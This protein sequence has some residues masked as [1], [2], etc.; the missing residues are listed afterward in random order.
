MTCF[1]GE[2]EVEILRFFEGLPIL[3]V[4][5]ST[6]R[7]VL[8][9]DGPEAEDISWTA[10]AV[11]ENLRLVTGSDLTSSSISKSPCFRFTLCTYGFRFCLSLLPTGR[12][13]ALFGVTCL[14]PSTGEAWVV[15]DVSAV[16]SDFF[17]CG[18]SF[19]QEDSVLSV[20]LSFSPVLRPL[21]GR[22]GEFLVVLEVGDLSF[23]TGFLVLGECSGF[24]T[25]WSHFSLSDMVAVPEIPLSE[26]FNASFRGL[27]GQFSTLL[28][29][30]SFVVSVALPP[31]VAGLL[32]EPV[33][34]GFT[35][36]T[37][38]F[39]LDE[40]VLSFCTGIK[41]FPWIRYIFPVVVFATITCWLLCEEVPLAMMVA[42]MGV[43]W[44]WVV[45]VVAV[46][47]C[48]VWIP[49]VL[50]STTWPPSLSDSSWVF[51]SDGVFSCCRSS[52]SEERRSS[53]L[54]EGIAGRSFFL[55]TLASWVPSESDFSVAPL[56]SSPMA[57]GSSTVL[58]TLGF[59]VIP[60]SLLSASFTS[61]PS[62]DSL[63]GVSLLAVLLKLSSLSTHT[64]RASS[65][66][67]PVLSV[68]HALEAPS[69]VLTFPVP[70]SFF[71]LVFPFSLHR[72]SNFP[73]L[74]LVLSAS[75]PVDRVLS[76]VLLLSS[77]APLK[78]PILESV[79]EATDS[80]SLSV[81]V[82]C[83]SLFDFSLQSTI[84]PSEGSFPP[85]HVSSLSSLLNFEF[86]S[87]VPTLPSSLTG[88]SAQLSAS[89]GLVALSSTPS[90]S[91]P[92]FSIDC[93]ATEVVSTAVAFSGFTSSPSHWFPT[94]LLILHED[95]STL[96][97]DKLSKLPS[98]WPS[99]CL[100]TDL[101]SLDS[102]TLISLDFASVFSHPF[103]PIV[104][105][106]SFLCPSEHKGSSFI[107]E[108]E[109]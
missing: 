109:T 49:R 65:T 69:I 32:P 33:V 93:G 106:V 94:S 61:S 2:L 17:E 102:L 99:S 79:T 14:F 7:F 35:I 46:C 62:S 24:L 20:C 104:S 22:V 42:L 71:W 66:P 68:S 31:F 15:E 57:L 6:D 75:R 25:L 26:T 23:F 101:L 92:D 87:E 85:V 98:S 3:T 89:I 88:L 107:I 41:M 36:I 27:L 84:F 40:S 63:A 51:L 47:C 18:L 58:Q 10:T 80:S 90:C 82:F 43:A 21:S 55:R 108:G 78:S 34:T 8:A 97:F 45:R 56:D 29:F 86:S 37:C 44:C 19:V 95:S 64:A 76:S 1:T 74:W 81:P 54:R 50:L 83:N 52:S 39:C 5:A 12:P 100:D 72:S 103:F 53:H 70:S 4:G 9:T 13:R 38:G 105:P 28:S 77:E 91:T 96:L 11:F 30:L 16:L 73:Q 67:E 59:S 60:V 48:T